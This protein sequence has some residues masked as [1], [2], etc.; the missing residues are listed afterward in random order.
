MALFQKFFGSEPIPADAHNRIDMAARSLLIEKGNRLILID[1]GLGTKQSEKFFSY[2]ALW[3]NHSLEN[4][5]WLL[6]GFLRMIS[7]MLFL[8]TFTLITVEELLMQRPDGMLVP[9]FPN[10]HFWCHQDH[11]NWAT[12]PNP[13][14]KASFLPE[15]IRPIQ[16]SGQLQFLNGTG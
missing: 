5:L 2:Y 15:N 1:T 4:V 12:N 16:E 6:L 13:R 3:G 8:H 11:W 10:A 14:E 9:A 7:P